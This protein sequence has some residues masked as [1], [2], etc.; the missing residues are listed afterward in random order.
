M[1]RPDRASVR[2]SDELHYRLK[3]QAAILDRALVEHITQLLT[4]GADDC[5]TWLKTNPQ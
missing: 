1:A 5:Q 4:A 3:C 2:I